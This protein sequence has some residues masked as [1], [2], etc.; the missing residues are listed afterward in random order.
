MATAE[1]AFGNEFVAHGFTKERA[2]D[3]D[4]SVGFISTKG[5]AGDVV[6]VIANNGFTTKEKACDVE[7]ANGFTKE[8]AGG[9]EVVNG[10]ITTKERAGDIVHVANGFITTKKQEES[11]DVEVVA[12]GFTTTNM[13]R[14]SDVEVVA[15]S[16]ITTKEERTGDDMEVL[17]DFSP[18]LL[19]YKSGRLE[20]PLIMPP[21]PP[22]HDEATGVVSKDVPLSASSFARLYLPPQ[23]VT[24]EATKLPVL[25]Y[26]HGGGFVIGSAA[27]CVYHRCIND[28]AAACPAVAVSV[29]YR[30]APEHLLPAAYE[31]S[32]AA[33]K[34]VLAASDPWL[35]AHGDLSRVFL[36]GDSAGGNICHHLAMH[37]DVRHVKLKG[38]VLIH[39]WFWGREPIAGEREH[40]RSPVGSGGSQMERK[41][42]LW[43]FVCPDA[44]DGVDDPRMNPTGPGAPGL[45]DLACEK[46]MVCV[47]E[48]DHLQ[49]RGKAY[50]E[51]ASKAKV[52]E[53]VESAGV[54]HVFYLLVPDMEEARELL[55]RIAG[56][57]NSKKVG[58]SERAAATTA[59]MTV[60]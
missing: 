32:L 27:T 31:D 21:V 43:E 51:A 6:E 39:P 2:G 4:V 30:L 17:H 25:V 60:E 13:E 57:V 19:V 36:A 11:R 3:V 5:G 48:G 52:V 15:N 34:W 1:R 50:A 53:T 54:G 24:E 33:L 55:A 20:R 40:R 12:N 28:L 45:E 18:L 26:F 46:V 23:A 49:W 7:V 9:V 41:M 8:K 44:A 38:I 58:A 37:P 22:G 56:F 42:N 35:A 29:D 14:A 10:F 16:F 47:A 59:I